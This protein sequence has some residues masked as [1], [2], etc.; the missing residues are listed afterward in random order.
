VCKQQQQ[1][2]QQRDTWDAIMLLKS[3]GDG[4]SA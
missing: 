3:M 2:Q 1:Q 4:L